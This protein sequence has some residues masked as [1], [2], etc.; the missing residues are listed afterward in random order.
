MP[1]GLRAAALAALAASVCA[2]DPSCSCSSFCNGTCAATNAGKPVK[3]TVYR[4][5]PVR[6][7]V[8]LHVLMLLPA[9]SAARKLSCCA[10]AP[11]PAPAAPP[12]PQPPPPPPPPPPL[13]LVKRRGCTSRRQISCSAAFAAQ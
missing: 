2:L 4:L 12:P 9:S 13:L 7:A 8:L 11:A 3:L 6:R 5:T 1:M 10:P